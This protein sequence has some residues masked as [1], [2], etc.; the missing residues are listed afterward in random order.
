MVAFQN[1]SGVKFNGPVT[2]SA[3]GG[4]AETAFGDDGT[5]R[6]PE[7]PV[8][9]TEPADGPPQ[10]EV[11]PVLL[12]P[13]ETG[14]Q[15]AANCKTLQGLYAKSGQQPSEVESLRQSGTSQL[16]PLLVSSVKSVRASGSSAVYLVG[17]GSGAKVDVAEVTGI[18]HI[19]LCGLNAGNLSATGN[20]T[21]DLVGSPV[22]GSV[23]TTGVARI[24]TF[25]SD[26]VAV[27]Q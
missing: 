7:L 14:A 18:G 8:V 25:T 3:K 15:L 26:G 4:D 16:G 27:S 5:V 20:S 21:L 11:P 10:A 12:P 17:A 23:R 1:C 6:I 24:R 22:R 13:A 9:I 2:S 19:I